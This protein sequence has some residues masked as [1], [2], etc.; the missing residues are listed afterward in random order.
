[1][2]VGRGM[3]LAIQDRFDADADDSGAAH[4]FYS[5]FLSSLIGSLA[6]RFGAEFSVE[7]L[8]RIQDVLE[9]EVPDT[10]DSSEHVH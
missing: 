1:M 4:L 6:R 10:S 7:L 3:W 2:L 8:K 9:H 5:G